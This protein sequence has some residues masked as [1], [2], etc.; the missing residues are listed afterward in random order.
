MTFVQIII[1]GVRVGL[2]WREG[3]EANFYT[4][5]NTE[6]R[7]LKKEF[8]KNHPLKHNFPR[9]AVTL[10]SSDSVDLNLVKSSSSGVGLGH[11]KDV[12]ILQRK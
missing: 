11:M 6:K 10:V 3:G 5:I 12:P 7:I 4:G 8:F 1:P 9:K 2:Q